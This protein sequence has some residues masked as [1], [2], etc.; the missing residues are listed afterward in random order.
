VLS[1]HKHQQSTS[2]SRLLKCLQRLGRSVV[3]AMASARLCV[4]LRRP[5]AWSAAT[6]SR[7]ARS[8]GLA[9]IPMLGGAPQLEPAASKV[10]FTASQLPRPQLSN[11]RRAFE[12]KLSIF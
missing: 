2:R 11:R 9:P 1:P 10:L 7:A 5:A 3:C 6:M 12:Q 8:I 4:R